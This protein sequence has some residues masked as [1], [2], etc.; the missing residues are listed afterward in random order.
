MRGLVP[1]HLV[2]QLAARPSQVWNT[3]LTLPAGAFVF[4]QAPS[5]RGKTTLINML[6]GLRTDYA[7]T[8]SFDHHNM[9]QL[10]DDQLSQL[11]ARSLSIVFQDLRLFPSLTAQENIESKRLLANAVSAEEVRS[12]M[13]QL[14]IADKA[15][16]KADTLSFGE[17]QRVAIIRALA[18]PFSWLLMD[19]PFSHL[20][21]ANRQR[22]I[23]LI[24]SE[25]RRR[26]AGIMLTDLDANNFFTYSHTL[27]M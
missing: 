20:D 21:V 24:D 1:A 8:I 6:Y 18:Q 12:W 25:V 26:N 14:G 15:H 17:Q 27:M 9:Q 23:D 13:D 16:A 4:V 10:S 3:E 22:A 11:R 2:N 7:G 19:E 5:G